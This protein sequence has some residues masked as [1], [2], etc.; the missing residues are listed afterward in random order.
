MDLNYKERLFVAY[1]LGESKGNASDAAARAG[2]GSTRQSSGQLG[3]RL[4]KKVQIR[5][6]IDVGFASVGMSQHE[7]LARMSDL[8]SATLGD[9]LEIGED[10][11]RVKLIKG[12][13]RGKLHTLKKVKTKTRTFRVNDEIQTEVETEIEIKDSFPA[14]AKMGDHHGLFK[15]QPSVDINADRVI[16]EC[17]PDVERDPIL[18]PTEAK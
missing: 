13:R 10:G 5:N 15:N 18:P 12:K 14:L 8:A 17:S 11:H 6:A 9:F 2:Y 7:V 16:F 3:Y 4:L 1:Y